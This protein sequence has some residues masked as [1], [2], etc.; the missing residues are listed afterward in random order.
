MHNKQETVVYGAVHD[1]I[2]VKS[3]ISKTRTYSVRLGEVTW[4]N[5]IG[6]KL[7]IY[8]VVEYNDVPQMF[9][10]P[11]IPHYLVEPD[12]EGTSDFIRILEAMTEIGRRNKLM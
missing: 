9:V 7:S 11:I 12:N 5:D 8:T 1:E 4:N 10:R 3:S 2:K 6:T